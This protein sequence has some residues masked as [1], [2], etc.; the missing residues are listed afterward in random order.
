MRICV[1]ALLAVVVTMA[2]CSGLEPLDETLVEL[3]EFESVDLPGRLWDP[4]F[5]D[6][7]TGDPVTV[8]GLLTVPPTD[9]PVP[10]VI[11]AHGCGGVGDAELSWVEDLESLG[12]ATFVI[13][14]FGGRGIGN[15]CTGRETI[16]VASPIV[17]LYRA[18]Q[19]LEDQPYVDTSRT[20]VMGFSFGGRTAIWSAFTRAQTA[21][22]GRPFAG[23]I[24][25]YPSTCYIQLA[26]EEAS[27]GPLRIFHGVEDDWTPI[28]QCVELVDRLAHDGYDASLIA[29][30]DAEHSFDDAS[31]AWSGNHFSPQAV[32]PRS[33]HFV[34]MDGVI[35]DPETGTVAGVDSVC[36]E[37]GVTYGY[38]AT[39]RAAAAE[40]LIAFL[41][42]VLDT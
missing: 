12:V 35:V 40:D 33:C 23:H 25:F 5:P 34:E 30:P 27:S 19:V 15:L 6:L 14:S 10:V 17:D 20:A 1:H 18:A 39:A 8:S 29:Y 31:L 28:D 22:E 42:Q 11:V 37:K 2:A 38:N 32:S 4:L 3:I 24:A 41:E 36:V 16:N 9:E 13:D 26:D 21:Y 7:E